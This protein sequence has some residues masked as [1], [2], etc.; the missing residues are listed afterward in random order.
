MKDESGGFIITFFVGL[1]SKKYTYLINT[2]KCIKK[3]KGIKYNIVQ[4]NIYFL[5]YVAYMNTKKS[6]NAKNNPVLC[7][8]YF[9]Y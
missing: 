7:L 4:N 2:E 5:N 1:R 8:Q 6:N 3:S 9:Q